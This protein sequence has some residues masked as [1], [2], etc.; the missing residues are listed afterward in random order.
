MEV[1]LYDIFPENSNLVSITLS[2]GNY[3]N[4]DSIIICKLGN[5]ARNASTVVT[6]TITPKILGVFKNL[7]RVKG[8]EYD[9]NK[10]NNISIFRISPFKCL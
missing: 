9:P 8:K 2:Q 5:L 4:L 3:Y 10:D 6:I 1:I 7:V